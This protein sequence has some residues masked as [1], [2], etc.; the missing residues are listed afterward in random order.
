[1][2]IPNCVGVGAPGRLRI[3]VCLA[4]VSVA[5]SLD[6]VII[7]SFLCHVLSSCLPVL[8]FQERD[9]PLLCNQQ[10]RL[11]ELHFGRGLLVP[12][13]CRYQGC[14]SRGT[15]EPLQV[16]LVIIYHT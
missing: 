12:G 14:S 16:L 4:S 15:L 8:S 13:V 10:Q 11:A 5:H 6:E 9:E 3:T 7:C 2:C 1:M